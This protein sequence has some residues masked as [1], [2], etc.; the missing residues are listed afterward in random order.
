MFDMNFELLLTLLVLLTGIITLFDYVFLRKRR[1]ARLQAAG[2]DILKLPLVIEYSRSFFPILLIVLLIRSFLMQPF[3]V[4]TGSLE[5]TVLP[6]DFIAVNQ[7]AYG[8]RLPVLHYKFLDLGEPKRG[9]IAVFRYPPDPSVNYVK[10]I[11]GVPGDKISY[12]DKVLY[13]NGKRI[14]QQVIGNNVDIEDP[15][16]PIPVVEKEENLLGV[17]HRIFLRPNYIG[18]GNFY[19]I[20]VPPEHYFAMGDNRDSSLDSR[21][22]GFVPESNLIG[23]A[24]LVW[25]SWDSHK[26]WFRWKHLGKLN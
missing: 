21:V 2:S 9:D 10:R 8:L 14:P 20:E 1:Q 13:V 17:K 12:I 7:Y 18:S 22:W 26:H 15:D 24:F 5:P 23:R 16:D 19:N 25:L 6:G 11:I 4:P 3:R